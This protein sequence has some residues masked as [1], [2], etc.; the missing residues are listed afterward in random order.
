MGEKP[1][2][3]ATHLA[4]RR[5]VLKISGEML[6]GSQGQGLKR[7][8]FQSLARQIADVRRAGVEIAV[9]VG[10]GNIFRGGRNDFPE[11]P[12]TTADDMGMLGTLINALALS[13]YI[14]ALGVSAPVLSAINA[15]KIAERFTVRRA[16]QILAAGAVLVLAGGTG[17]PFFT[18]DTAAA[19]RAAELEADVLLKAT[20]VD[21]VY[22][23]DPRRNPKAVKYETLDYQKVLSEDLR[24][25]DASAVAICRDA[26]IPVIVFN[27][28]RKGQIALAVKGQSVGTF[29]G[30][31]G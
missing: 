16:R 17:N 31:E 12:Q 24:V 26:Q 7:R 18:T 28:G 23:G 27:V 8:T 5:P 19:L 29:I 1:K 10:A 25:M 11:I 4:Y 9:V 3:A 2:S 14:G 13:E 30:G 15:P 20:N 22:S 6:G 21:G